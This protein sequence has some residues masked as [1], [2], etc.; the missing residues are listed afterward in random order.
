MFW[1]LVRGLAPN[2][3]TL[4][5]HPP[6]AIAEAIMAAAIQRPNFAPL[7]SDDAPAAPV[8][9]IE[10]WNLFLPFDTKH[11]PPL[12]I[13]CNLGAKADAVVHEE[14]VDI[15]SVLGWFERGA[16]VSKW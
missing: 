1:V 6:I 4:V 2:S 16:G 9:T 10:Q 7:E 5:V 8:S 15:C 13:R 11:V 14:N 3:V 12:Y